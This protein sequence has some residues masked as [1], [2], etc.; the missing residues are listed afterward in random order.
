MDHQ[1]IKPAPTFGNLGKDGLKLAVLG[2]IERGHNVGLQPF[3]QGADM[4]FGL[5]VQPGDGKVC[6]LG[7]QRLGATIGDRVIVGDAH[8]QRLV[9][10]Q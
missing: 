9:T 5:G 2:D 7:P 8:D 3:G 1:G 10:R 6:A 4:G